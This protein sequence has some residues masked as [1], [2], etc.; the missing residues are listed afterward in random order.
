M[1]GGG[2]EKPQGEENSAL[3]NTAPFNFT[4]LSISE[5]A[6]T[7]V[8]RTPCKVRRTLRKAIHIR[9]PNEQEIETL[10]YGWFAGDTANSQS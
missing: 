6:S 8:L 4:P 9:Q 5:N 10:G 2:V 7:P 1:L 3:K